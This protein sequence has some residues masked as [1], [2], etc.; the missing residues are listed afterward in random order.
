[1]YAKHVVPESEP[2]PTPELQLA[3]TAADRGSAPDWQ[4]PEAFCIS[5]LH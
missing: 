5:K 3:L 1:M 4:E 2:R